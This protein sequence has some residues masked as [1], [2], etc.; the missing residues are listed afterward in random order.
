MTDSHNSGARKAVAVTTKPGLVEP[1]SIQDS[2]DGLIFGIISATIIEA[3]VSSNTADAQY[4]TINMHC[5][6]GTYWWIVHARRQKMAVETLMPSTWQAE[7]NT[8][9]SR[10]PN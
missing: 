6:A 1:S 9:N 8:R 10:H 2:W 3:E 5:T 7:I 4:D